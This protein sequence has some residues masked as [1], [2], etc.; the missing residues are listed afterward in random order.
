[1]EE[2]N[3]VIG[4]IYEHYKKL[5]SIRKEHDYLFTATPEWM[6]TP[7]GMYGYEVKGTGE[8]AYVIHNVTGS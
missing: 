6:G 5:I 8:N 7:E 1:L 3:G 4:I 2:Q